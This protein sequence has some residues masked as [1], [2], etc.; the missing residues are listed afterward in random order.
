VVLAASVLVQVPKGAAKRNP[1][2]FVLSAEEVEMLKARFVAFWYTPGVLALTRA[3]SMTGEEL[4]VEGREEAEE[5]AAS[6][7]AAPPAAPPA[8][9]GSELDRHGLPKSLR[10]DDY[11]EDDDAAIGL[12]DDD[13]ADLLDEDDDSDD[14]DDDEEDDQQLPSG[15]F[16]VGGRAMA[17]DDSDASDAEDDAINSTDALLLIAKTEEDFSSLEV[18]IYE[19]S[20]GNLYGNCIIVDAVVDH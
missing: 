1:E 16:G 5:A 8:G 18:Q 13:N 17:D 4:V 15:A 12:G 7:A 14:S 19:E 6:A 11:D 2:K 20:T 10:M 9:S 3:F